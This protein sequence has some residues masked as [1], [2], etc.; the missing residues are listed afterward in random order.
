MV[1]TDQ[2]I[3][4]SKQFRQDLIY[5]ANVG[6][7]ISKMIYI[8]D[9]NLENKQSLYH[10]NNCFYSFIKSKDIIKS[11]NCINMVVNFSNYLE[12]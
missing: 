8:D 7:D 6:K 5:V 11:K 4:D 9:I 10:F 3:I 1:I 2:T 12:Y